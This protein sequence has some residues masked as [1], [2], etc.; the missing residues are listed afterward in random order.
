[1]NSALQLIYTNLAVLNLLSIKELKAIKLDTTLL[2]IFFIVISIAFIEYMIMGILPWV[3]SIFPNINKSVVDSLLLSLSITPIIYLI[4][5]KKISTENYSK[6][7]IRSK[8]LI[9]S[10]LPLIISISLMVNIVNEKQ[11]EIVDLELAQNIIKFDIQVGQIIDAYNDEVIVSTNLIIANN[12]LDK[13]VLKEK[14]EATNHIVNLLLQSIE[15][16][17]IQVGDFDGSY[18]NEFKSK[19]NEI[20]N[21]IDNNTIS[22][23]VFINYFI[24]LNNQTI[25]RLDTFSAQINHSEIGARRSNYLTS[26]KL[27]MLNNINHLILSST[28]SFDLINTKKI[29]IRALKNKVRNQNNQEKTYVDIFKSTLP[30]NNKTEILTLLNSDI[31]KKVLEREVALGEKETELL[32]AKL[33]VYMGY[34]GLIHQF[35]NFVLRDDNKY[36]VSFLTL[37]DEVNQV[38]SKLADINKYN[39]Q[40]LFHLNNFGAVIR[41]YKDNLLKINGLRELGKSASEIDAIVAVDDTKA[42]KALEYMENS[43]WEYNPN[44][45]LT[46]IKQKSLIINKI[47][48]LLS[49]NAQNTLVKILLNKKQESY[50]TAA[51]ALI[52]ILFV[53]TL[54]FIIIRNISISYEERTKALEKAEEA[55]KMK[56]EFLAN[57]SHEI[58]TP[59]NGVIGMLGLLMN[60][61]LTEEQSHRVN[62]ANSSANSLLTLI[63]DILDFSK[64]EAGKLELEFIDFNLPNLLGEFAESI[65]LSAQ[66]KNV[67]VIIDL[68]DVKYSFIKSDPGRIRQILTNILSNAIK[69]TEQGEILIKAKLEPAENPNY[70]I[71]SCKIKDTGIGIPEDKISSLFGVFSQVDSSTTRKYG[72]T[73]LGLSIT[74]KLCNLLNGD[75]TVTSE[76]GVGSCFEITLLVEKSELSTMMV[77]SIDTSKLNI[78]IVDD[79]KTNREVLRGQLECWGIKVTEAE[80]GDEALAL[81]E[82]S[83]TSSDTPKF[84]IALLDMQMPDMSGETLAKNIRKNN[85]YQTLKLV[86]MTSMAS[87]GDAK[88]FAAIGFSAYFSKPTTTLDLFNA[89]AVITDDGETLKQAFPLI[90]KDF[91]NKLISDSNNVDQ[92]KS[93]SSNKSDLKGDTPVNNWLRETRVLLVEDNRIN[94]MVA[95]SVLK[96]IGLIADVAANGVE[97]INSLKEAINIKPYTLVIMDCQ[98]PEMDG[99]EA[100]KRI[101]GGYAG[102]ENTFIPII[103]MTANAMQGDKEKCINAGMDDY[104]SKP[105]NPESVHEKLILWTNKKAK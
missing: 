69:F 43:L 55:A 42:N 92:K 64:V 95:L 13:K 34:N 86:M 15:K 103:A 102:E 60:S 48:T 97:A 29:D 78:L 88:H 99:Y 2:S 37:Y 38:I 53:I 66:N 24:D 16:N 98:M 47:D 100:T 17:N 12:T 40:A 56:S 72:G 36:K 45:M 26:L 63:N 75:V 31:I 1:M 70:F 61:E 81:C 62:V 94:Q 77:P 89:L 35:K 41:E 8:L 3:Q 4:I 91:T 25:S 20:R 105:I 84:D 9:S 80:G 96:N 51:V 54:L 93:K 79:N 68:A 21:K 73:G 39:E 50:I 33:A 57:M 101:R 18:L 46:L 44:Y 58:R 104:L 22:L 10:G 67:E 87:Q 5:K 49:D 11:N 7:A 30:E 19:L 82:K 90:T 14:R 85:N 52:L 28:I 6:S 83:F 23:P 71:F 32:V 65:A 27:K 76:P 74:K 59:M